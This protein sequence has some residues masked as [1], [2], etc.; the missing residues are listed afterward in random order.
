MKDL[1]LKEQIVHC[2]GR[3]WVN[4][5][6]VERFAL[7]RGYKASNG[8]RRARELAEN[9][10]LQRKEQDG[11]VW[12]RLAPK[13]KKEESN[14]ITISGKTVPIRKEKKKVEVSKQQT[15]INL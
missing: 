13:E 2:I 14:L 6:W 1:S 12:Y 3:E 7:D 15:L 10:I 4:G 8:S 9:G 11:S 5:G